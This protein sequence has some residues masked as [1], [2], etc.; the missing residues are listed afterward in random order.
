MCFRCVGVDPETLRQELLRTHGIGVVALGEHY[1]RVAFSS[2][3]EEKIPR[4]Y[5]TIY[6][7]ASKLCEADF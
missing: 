7:T 5:Q 4:V 1:L 3:D 6:D 2:I